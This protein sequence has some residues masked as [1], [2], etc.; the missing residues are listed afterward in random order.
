MQELHSL[1]ERYCSQRNLDFDSYW[2]AMTAGLDQQHVSTLVR[3]HKEW[4][5]K[6]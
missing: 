1:V 3:Y 2:A 5:A 6:G 4:L